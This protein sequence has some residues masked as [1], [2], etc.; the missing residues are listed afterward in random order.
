[1]AS[2]RGRRR[3]VGEDRVVRHIE[4]VVSGLERHT[5]V[6]D[7]SWVLGHKLATVGID[8]MG[9]VRRSWVLVRIGLAVLV[10]GNSLVGVEVVVHRIADVL[11]VGECC[12]LAAARTRYYRSNRYL[13]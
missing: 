4:V 2:C 10:V 9:E 12:S 8:L 3:I 13:T 7:R 1:M 5:T 6:L 11:V